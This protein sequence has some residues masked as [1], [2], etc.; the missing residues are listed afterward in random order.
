MSYRQLTQEQR[1]VND[2]ENKLNMRFV[3]NIYEKNEF[4]FK[5]DCFII[6]TYS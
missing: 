5:S 6:L 2:T 3:E 1:F 4:S